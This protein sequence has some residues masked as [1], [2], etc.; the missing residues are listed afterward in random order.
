MPRIQHINETFEFDAVK[1]NTYGNE[2]PIKYTLEKN[3]VVS[4]KFI[5]ISS[6]IADLQ[7]DNGILIPTVH[8]DAFKYRPF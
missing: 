6:G 3:R 2:V 4:G 1:I 5:N 7:L 8:M